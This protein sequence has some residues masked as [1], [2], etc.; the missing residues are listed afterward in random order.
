MLLILTMF[1][2]V[3]MI[4]VFAMSRNKNYEVKEQQEREMR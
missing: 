2:V 1:A 4:V 3:G